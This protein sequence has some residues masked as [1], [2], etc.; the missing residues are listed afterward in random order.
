MTAS[1]SVPTSGTVILSW[2]CQTP[3]F[4]Y[5]WGPTVNEALF[6]QPGRGAVA[7]FGP[8]GVTAVQLQPS[9]VYSRVVRD[10]K[11]R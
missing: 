6:L 5:L 1:T 9:R 8:D 2:A 11:G 4:Q 10:E 3:F 7:A